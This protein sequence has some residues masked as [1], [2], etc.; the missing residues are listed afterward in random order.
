MTGRSAG[1]VTKTSVALH[2]PAGIVQFTLDAPVL[3]RP[4]AFSVL[5][6]DLARG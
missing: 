3:P 2:E 1:L 6:N 5:V 4:L